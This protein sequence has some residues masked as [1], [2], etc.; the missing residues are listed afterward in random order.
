MTKVFGAYMDKFLKVFVDD[1]NI[2][3]LNWEH[4]KHLWYVSYEVK[5]S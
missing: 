4:L 1:L 2:Y 3:N 5:G